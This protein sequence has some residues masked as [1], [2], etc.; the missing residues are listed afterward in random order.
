[1]FKPLAQDDGNPQQVVMQLQ[2]AVF[3]QSR[4][5]ETLHRELEGPRQ[6]SSLANFTLPLDP[7]QKETPASETKE[8]I[9]RVSLLT[10]ANVVTIFNPQMLKNPYNLNT[11]PLS[12]IELYCAARLWADTGLIQLDSDIS[13]NTGKYISK[14]LALSDAQSVRYTDAFSVIT[15]PWNSE[16][17]EMEND[18]WDKAVLKLMQDKM[19][20]R[21]FFKHVLSLI[22]QRQGAMAVIEMKTFESDIQQWQPSDA[23]GQLEKQFLLKE[24]RI[25]K[26][27][28]QFPTW[29]GLVSAQTQTIKPHYTRGGVGNS[30]MWTKRGVG[31]TTN[32][33]ML[34]TLMSKDF[35]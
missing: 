12:C 9:Q 14:C 11:N 13:I 19:L 3:N 6:R 24:L 16:Y 25:G 1:M 31:K 15:V 2:L 22:G 34:H 5:E 32:A 21:I 33:L 4:E 23:T 28:Q 18:R 17:S 27:S 20:G 10:L 35:V 30:G 26:R 8:D 29:T 7:E